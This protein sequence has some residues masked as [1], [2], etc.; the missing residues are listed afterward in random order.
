MCLQC[1]WYSM[2]WVVDCCVW[3]SISCLVDWFIVG[4]A[5]AEVGMN[6]VPRTCCSGMF[7]LG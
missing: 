4:V 2:S 1:I 3:D 6:E 5:G 7:D